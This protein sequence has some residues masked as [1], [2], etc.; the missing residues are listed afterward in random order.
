MQPTTIYRFLFSVLTLVFLGLTSPAGATEI[1]HG[2]NLGIGLN[3]GFPA[4]VSAK[5]FLSPAH[6]VQVSAGYWPV[7]DGIKTAA[8]DW[9]AHKQYRL[10]GKPYTLYA[11]LGFG[12]HRWGAEQGFNHDLG[13]DGYGVRVPLGLMKMFD[14]VPVEA[15]GELVIGYFGGATEGFHMDFCAILRVYF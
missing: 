15:G 3:I 6:A 13:V 8:I 5:Y 7:G 10:Q 11:G 12:Y 14:S 2:K 1:G 4:G 9:V